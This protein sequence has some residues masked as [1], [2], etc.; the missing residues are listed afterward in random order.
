M[1][2]RGHYRQGLFDWGASPMPNPCFCIGGTSDF[3]QLHGA[4]QPAASFNLVFSS[5][6]PGREL[7][8]GCSGPLK[9]VK[10]SDLA[11]LGP[12]FS[13]NAPTTAALRPTA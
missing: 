7:P 3:T 5:D 8:L 10:S 4:S 2:Y 9:A 1:L 13:T 11:K 6:Y 12:D